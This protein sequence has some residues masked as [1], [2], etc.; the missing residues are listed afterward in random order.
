MDLD[1]WIVP[2]VVITS[3]PAPDAA[4]WVPVAD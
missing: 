2:G 4:G 1:T 3:T